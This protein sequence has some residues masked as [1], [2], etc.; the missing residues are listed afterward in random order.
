MGMGVTAKCVLDYRTSRG[1]GIA[2]RILRCSQRPLVWITLLKTWMDGPI[3]NTQVQ[4]Q[5]LEFT[6][7]KEKSS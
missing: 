5:A 4:M 6:L 2:W 3:L 1:W 7:E